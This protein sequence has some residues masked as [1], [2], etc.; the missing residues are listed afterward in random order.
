MGHATATAILQK[1]NMIVPNLLQTLI[2]WLH[3]LNHTTPVF[4]LTQGQTGQS[5]KVWENM[6][7]SRDDFNDT[8]SGFVKRIIEITK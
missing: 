3:N 6:N 5:E 8:F 4:L 7:K 1:N 2:V